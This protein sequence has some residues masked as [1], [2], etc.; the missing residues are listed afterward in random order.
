VL[1]AGNRIKFVGSKL[2]DIAGI[3]AWAPGPNIL[4]PTSGARNFN[5]LNPDTGEE[6]PLVEKDSELELYDAQYSPDGKKVVVLGNR[7]PDYGLWVISLEDSSQIFLRKGASFPIGWSSDGKWV[8]SY[9]TKGG[10]IKI[11]MIGVE[12]GQEKAV[13]TIPFTFELGEP[14]IPCMIP[15]GRHFVIP[16]YKTISD[17]W[18]FENFDPDIK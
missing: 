15:G 12:N 6:T 14:S 13:A 9:A 3:L 18:M 11:L 4:Y 10:T 8:Y 7:P 17:V 16:V 2:G 1:V 5:V